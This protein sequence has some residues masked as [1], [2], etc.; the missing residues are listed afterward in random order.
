V[1]SSLNTLALLIVAHRALQA[2]RPAA[3]KQQNRVGASGDVVID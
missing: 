2:A 1:V 3:L